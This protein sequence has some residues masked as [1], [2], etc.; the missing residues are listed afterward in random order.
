MSDRSPQHSN[1]PLWKSIDHLAGG[2]AAAGEF[3][4][5]T[6]DVVHESSV[7]RRGFM[8]LVSASMALTATACRRP[9][10]KLVPTV[11]SAQ[12]VTPGL[13]LEYSTVFSDGNIAQGAVVRSREGRPIS[14]KGNQQHSITKGNATP[15]MQATLLSL[16]D[17]DRMRRSRVNS[18]DTSV[19]NALQSIAKGITDAQTQGKR[20][21]VLLA[22]HASPSLQALCNEISSAIPSVQ[23]VRMQPISSDNTAIAT[24]AVFGLD[25]V[26]APSL[27]HASVIVCVDADPLGTDPLSNVHTAAFSQWRKPT[28][29]KP[30]MSTLIVAEA[31]YSLT[32]AN[33]DTR[34]R[35]HPSQMDSFIAL[36]H[37][38][39][40]G[41]NLAP[42]AIA[43]ASASTIERAKETSTALKGAQGA[44][45]FLV[46]SHLSARSQALGLL[47]NDALGCVGAGKTYDSSRVVPM[48]NNA[49][50]D[51]AAFEQ[52]LQNDQVHTILFAGVNPEYYGSRSLRNA[53]VKAPVRAAINLYEDETATVCS[54]SIPAAH[55][56]ESWGDAVALDGTLSIQ[57]PLIAP[58]NEGVPALGD[59]LIQLT[60][61]VVPSFAPKETTPS[62]YAY[63]KA[64][65]M[66]VIKA[67]GAFNVES[68]WNSI[69][70]RGTYGTPTQAQAIVAN[71]TSVGNLPE[72]L[73]ENDL[74]LLTVPSLSLYDGAYANNGWLQEVPDPVT[75][76]TWDNVALM[77][78][79]TA[80]TLGIAASAHPKDVVKANG[81]VVTLS[82]DHG[83]I[84]LPVWVQVGMADN[85]IAMALGYGRKAGGAVMQG[86]GANAY[87][88]AAPN[89]AVGYIK[90]KTTEVTSN[91]HKVACAQSHHTLDDGHGERP[92]AKWITMGDMQAKNFDTL[93]EE[94]NGEGTNGKYKT[95][96]SIT[97][98]YKY[99]GHRWAMVIDM[100]SCT[101]C[102]ACV[103]ACQM[104]NNISVVGKEQVIKGREM[105]WIRLDRYY[106]GDMENPQTIV[107]PMLC[108]HC[109]NA[110]CENVC[111]VAAT[112]HSP[113]GLNE[114]TYN[115]CVGTRYC[116][117][118]CPYKVRRFNFLNY[119]TET[120]SPAELVNNPDVTVRMR[121]IM[122]K[123]TFCV[124]RL[125]EAKW[126]AKDQG[127]SRVLDGEAVTACQEACPAGSIYFG[128]VNDNKSVV[129]AKR[130]DD[131]GF[132]V[133][134]ELNVRPQV[135][136]L[137]KVR[138]GNVT[139]KTHHSSESH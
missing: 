44:C 10:Q 113:E 40:T 127:R 81:T 69:L 135:T 87:A 102:S 64:R 125:H 63:V 52:S 88:I 105:H 124:Q 57:Q 70:Q 71:T 53:L 22:N 65:W 21:V 95:P 90:A 98:D 121:G 119:N 50:N 39:I 85:T 72:V 134:A 138:H 41:T 137:A 100:S 128:D 46:G 76:I 23:F 11:K 34:I 62:Y 30:V 61:L 136:Y 110:P 58:L 126:H 103:I 92:V 83:G 115:R 59:L 131:R 111:P 60:R 27:E 47:I 116:L 19:D 24:K 82:T 9:L 32:G 4:A 73:V 28:V 68:E 43:A 133:L 45:A 16:Y 114:M 93:K 18:G 17:P 86:V 5:G 8:A 109:E 7:S 25:A 67:T 96:L 20:S 38:T 31:Q 54:V 139:P 78:P 112:T 108:Q 97:N 84:D 130:Q 107:E 74:M 2:S 75:K 15:L 48:S 37:Q 118:N 89:A 12:T 26:L 77:S 106:T 35:I 6:T 94:F 79:K 1:A 14:I 129:S 51:L 80:Q 123:C 49:S 120:R 91:R 13:P 132:H 56:L 33:A 99:N 104:E 66:E 29:E 3:A 117:N 55:W 42:K 36:V 101:G 122:E